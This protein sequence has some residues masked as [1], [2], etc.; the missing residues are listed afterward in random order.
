MRKLIEPLLYI[1]GFTLAVKLILKLKYAPLI[2][3]GIVTKNISISDRF[4]FI[5][6]ALVWILSA[7]IAVLTIKNATKIGKKFLRKKTK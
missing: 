1:F 2:L 5:G 3:L 4:Y 7:L 6:L